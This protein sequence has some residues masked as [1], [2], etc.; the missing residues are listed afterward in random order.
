MIETTKTREQLKPICTKQLHG[1]ACSLSG[2]VFH[3]HEVVDDYVM[4][5]YF[6]L[7]V[8]VNVADHVN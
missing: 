4:V 7:L 1:V 5:F 8:Q 3:M 2:P 6:A